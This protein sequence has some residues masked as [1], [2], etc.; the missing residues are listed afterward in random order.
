MVIESINVISR[1][2]GSNCEGYSGKV[3]SLFKEEEN[4][5][6]HQIWLGTILRLNSENLLEPLGPSHLLEQLSTPF[7]QALAERAA[8]VECCDL[9]ARVCDVA[10]LLTKTQKE[11]VPYV[12]LAWAAYFE[13]AE[14]LWDTESW[15]CCFNRFLRAAQLS[16]QGITKEKRPLQSYGMLLNEA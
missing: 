14:D 16:W 2:S 12:S 3:R 4:S 7:Y 11:K 1:E 9:R 5:L 10:Q 15:S 8:E 13:A 6:I